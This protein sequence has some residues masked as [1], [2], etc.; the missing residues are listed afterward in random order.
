MQKILEP[1][2]VSILLPI[3]NEATH[4]Q[5]CLDTIVAQDYASDRLEVLVIDG[6]STDG[7]RE[8]VR[9][10]FNTCTKFPGYLLDNPAHIVPVALNIGLL[11]AKGD[12]IIRVDG[13]CEIAQDYISCCVKHLIEDG[14]DG[15]GGSVETIGD[16]KISQG[17]AI[18]MSSTFGVGGSTFRTIKGKQLYTDSI[19]F[20]AYTQKTIDLVGLY[21]EEMYCNE[22]DEY[23]YRLRKLGMRLLLANDIKSRYYCRSSFI[24]LWKQYFKYGFWKVRVLQKHPLQMRPRQFIPPIFILGLIGSL[25]FSLTTSLGWVF[26]AIILIS[27]LLSDLTASLLISM[28]E[29]WKY[30]VIL[31][32]TFPVLHFS[33]GIGFLSGLLKFWG[34]WGDKKGKVP[35]L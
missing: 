4:I 9:T 32:I 22:D 25:V 15:V 16:T 26:F 1:P 10:V 29:G 12:I 17:I 19:P 30:L 33:Y 2:F 28:K 8:I 18:A 27:Y 14:V 35:T 11:K 13:H 20:P 6:L 7:T 21:D 24:S 34:R 5:R 23:N 3:L 31:P